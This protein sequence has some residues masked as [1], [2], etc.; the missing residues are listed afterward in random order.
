MGPIGCPETSARYYHYS[1]SNDP[2]DRSSQNEFNYYSVWHKTLALFYVLKI[3]EL[4]T[5]VNV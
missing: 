3:H 1:L 2:E 4:M 5:Q